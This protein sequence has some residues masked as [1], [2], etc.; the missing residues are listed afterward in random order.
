MVLKEESCDT[1]MPIKSI[2]IRMEMGDRKRREEHLG[3]V[4]SLFS[5][6]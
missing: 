3:L 1:N 5:E 4:S 6:V 2:R